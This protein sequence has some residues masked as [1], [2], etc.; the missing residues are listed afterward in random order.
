VNF[1]IKTFGWANFLAERKQ[2][3]IKKPIKNEAKKNVTENKS[4]ISA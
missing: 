4:R 3:I 2:Y 1:K